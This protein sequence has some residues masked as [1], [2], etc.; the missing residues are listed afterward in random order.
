MTRNKRLNVAIAIAIAIALW[1][2]V[3][4][5]LDPSSVKKIKNIPITPLHT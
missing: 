5:E 3:V 4:G 2:Y 1:I